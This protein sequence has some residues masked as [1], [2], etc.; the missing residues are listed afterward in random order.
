[1]L[2]VPVKAKTRVEDA[3]TDPE[4]TPEKGPIVVVDRVSNTRYYDDRKRTHVF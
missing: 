1:V 3:E 4:W 2:D